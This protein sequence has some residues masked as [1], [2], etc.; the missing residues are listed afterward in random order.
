VRADFPHTASGWPLGLSIARSP[1]S[2]IHAS[3]SPRG[4]HP[5]RT[6]QHVEAPPR[7]PLG[8]RPQSPSQFSRF[9]T[10]LSPPG[11][12]G[13]VAPAIPSRLPASTTQPPQGPFPPAALFVAAFV[14]RSSRSGLRYF[15]PLG[16]PLHRG[17]LRHWLIRRASPRRGPCR[18]AS[19]VPRSSVHACCAP[20]PAGTRRALRTQRVEHRLRRDMSGSAPGLFIC[21]GCRLHLM[22]RPACSPP[23]AQRQPLPH[24]LSTPRS[25]VEVSPE[26]MGS[27]T[28]RSGTYRGGTC[29]RWKSAASNGRPP[30]VASE[31]VRRVTAHHGSE[32]TDRRPPPPDFVQREA[33]PGAT[34]LP[35]SGADPP[36]DPAAG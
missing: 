28:R 15:D 11:L 34:R 23:A 30:R 8:C 14:S 1:R 29:T 3:A 5:F 2:N 22:L 35:P 13:P 32:P 10:R 36:D 27:A 9:S 6:V 19:R 26:Q 12:L 31:I 21:R 20:Y 33:W 17:R 18:R 16:L 7:I 4:R 25:S 24:G